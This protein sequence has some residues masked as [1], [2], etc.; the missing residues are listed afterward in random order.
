ML[1]G[2]A[3]RGAAAHLRGAAQEAA[4]ADGGAWVFITLTCTWFRDTGA[5][6]A[7]RFI[8]PAWPKLYE[9][10][11][12][13]KT[14]IGGAR[15]SGRLSF[16]ALVLAKLWYLP[17]LTWARLRADRDSRPTCSGRSATCASRCSSARSASRTRASSCPVTAACSTASTR[18]C[19][20]RRTS[21][22]SRASASARFA[23]FAPAARDLPAWPRSAS[24]PLDDH[25]QL[26]ELSRP[27]SSMPY[28]R[29]CGGDGISTPLAWESS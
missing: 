9:S 25:D 23:S 3:L 21:T 29:S 4:A 24:R 8:G 2:V 20:R 22:S 11:S 1:A 5:Y 14:V 10:V 28:G 13:K 18:C 16:G 17:S 27:V 15:R 6:F 12:P 7:G 26:P 19:S